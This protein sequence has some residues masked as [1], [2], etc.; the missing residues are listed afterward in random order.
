MPDSAPLRLAQRVTS[1]KPSPTLTINAKAKHLKAQGVDL[2]NLS[3]GEPDFDTPE[4]IKEAAV[5]AIRDGFTKYT[6]VGGIPELKEAVIARLAEDYAVTYRPEQILVSTGGKQALYNIAQALLDPGDEVIIPVPYWVSYPPIVELAGGV[7]RYLETRAEA[8][9][10]IDPAALEALVGPRT[11]AIILNSPSNPTGCVYSRATLA[12]VA[13]VAAAHGLVVI[14]DDIYDRIRFDG[15]PPENILS[16]AP[17]LADRVVLVNGVSK[18]YAMTGWRIGYMAGPEALVKAATRVQGQ[19]TSN[20]NSIAQM[21]ALAA[22][23]GPQECVDRM[24]AAFR[25]RRDFITRRLNALPGVTCPEPMGAFYAFA[26]LSAYHGARAG[27]RAIGDSLAMT[28]Y[29]LD[30]ARIASVPG[31][32]FGDDRFVRF[33]YASDLATLEAAL[34]RLE[35]ALGRLTRG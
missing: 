1:L 25:E 24:T 17:D 7:P 26:D 6:P 19:S 16:V 22:L 20:P 32:A 23:T 13:R 30:E 28:D 21:A 10:D 14:S 18:T 35:A 3:A 33:S 15:R 9:F 31:V 8:G 29:L 12:A 11:R 5:K 2:A 34:A 4:H 27:D